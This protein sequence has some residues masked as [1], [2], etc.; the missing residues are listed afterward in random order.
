MEEHFLKVIYYSEI[1]KC[2]YLEIPIHVY[3]LN[4][5]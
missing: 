1:V 3:S 4:Q 2:H 5:K